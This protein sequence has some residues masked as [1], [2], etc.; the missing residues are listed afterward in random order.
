MLPARW[1]AFE[2]L[3]INANGKVDRRRITD[4]FAEGISAHA[5]QAAHLA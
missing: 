5:A 4:V 2:E 3:P 1:L